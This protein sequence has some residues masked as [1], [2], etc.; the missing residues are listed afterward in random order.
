MPAGHRHS[1]RVES[2]RARTL[3]VS[4]G[5]FERFFA[6]AGERTDATLPPAVPVVPPP[7]RLQDAARRYGNVFDLD[8]R[9]LD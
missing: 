2:L 7:E 4:T 1:F 5:G 6:A 8:A 3:G 9:L